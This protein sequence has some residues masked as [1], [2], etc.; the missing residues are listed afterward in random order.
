[1]VKHRNL[2]GMG[3]PQDLV[4]AVQSLELGSEHA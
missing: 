4:H 3:H 1:M 2:D